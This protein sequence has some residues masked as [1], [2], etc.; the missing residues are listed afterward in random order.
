[1]VLALKGLRTTKKKK[2]RTREKYKYR[3]L[4]VYEDVSKYFDTFYVYDGYESSTGDR[5]SVTMRLRSMPPG[6][7]MKILD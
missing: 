5:L 7:N 2:F 4:R 6:V 3:K 1:M